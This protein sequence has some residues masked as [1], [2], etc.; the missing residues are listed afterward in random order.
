MRAHHIVDV[1]HV[2]PGSREALLEAVAVHHVPEWPRRSRLVIANAGINKD[3]VVRRLYDEALY[4]QYQAAADRIDECWL[5]PGA[6]LL[7]QFFGERWEEFHRIE[8][9]RL[10]YDHLVN[11]D[12]PKCDCRRHR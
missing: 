9:R 5:Q 4:A 2:K 6:V 1:V 7:K 8:E 11:R 10:L 12:V 3:V